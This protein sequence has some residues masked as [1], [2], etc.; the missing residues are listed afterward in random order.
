M[1][2]TIVGLF[3][4]LLLATSL[5]GCNAGTSITLAEPRYTGEAANG[6]P[7]FDLKWNKMPGSKAYTIAIYAEMGDFKD[8]TEL[9]TYEGR[10]SKSITMLQGIDTDTVTYRIKVRASGSNSLWSN[11]WEIRFVD[12]DYTVS[13]TTADFDP[14]AT[15]K[16]TVDPSKTAAPPKEPVAHSFPESLLEFGRKED[17]RDLYDLSSTA[18]LQVMVN[19]CEYG[20]PPQEITDPKVIADVIAALE[21]ILVTGDH[22]GRFSTGTYYSYSLYDAADAYICGFAFQDGM[23]MENEGRYPVSG[24]SALLSVEGVMLEEEWEA[25]HAAYR[26][27]QDA[28]EAAFA[29]AYPT[30]V[31]AAGGYNTSLLEGL[32]HD[33]LLSINVRVMWNDDAGRLVSDDP[34]VVAQLYDILSAAKVTGETDSGGNGQKWTIT[35]YYVTEAGEAGSADIQFVGDTL[36]GHFSGAGT[37]YFGVTGLDALFTA[38]DADVLRYLAAYRNTPLPDPVY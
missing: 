27:K 19:H 9:N 35:F 7:S 38:T 22:D 13:A 17:R 32:P 2:R 25:Y 20:E 31:F 24:L 30:S 6:K 8:R 21:G 16:P 11:I 37:R 1:K 12:G 23:L 10:T 18:T 29:P 26:E 4:L 34:K 5:F 28:Y 3:S 36:S 33:R 15:P 14:P